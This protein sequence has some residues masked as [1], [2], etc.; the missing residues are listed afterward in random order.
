MPAMSGSHEREN[1]MA[2]NAGNARIFGNDADAIYLAP[3]GT[4]LPT[5]IDEALDSAFEDVGWLHSDGITETFT[6][7]KTE[8]RGHQGQ[9]VVRTRIETPGTTIGFHALESK[10]QTKG[11]RYDEKTVTVSDGVRKVRR[12]A[13]Q[14]VQ[15][16]AA[17]IDIFDADDVTVKERHV[18]ERFEVVPDGDRVFTGTDIAGFPFLGEIIGDYDTFEGVGASGTATGW[19]VTVEGTPT[20]GTYTLTVNGYTTAGIAYNATNTAVA[21][22]INALSGVTG[23]SGVTGSGSGT[24][25]LTFPSPVTLTGNGSGLTGGED[26]DVT[27]ATA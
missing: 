16:R 11:L 1:I 9:K 5:T 8:I 3:L 13:G 10:P 14:K 12:G 27:V 6:G 2:V 18:I 23:I 24:I 15:A 17:V 22:A 21:A 7:S 20:G 4:P 25:T 19:T 26:P